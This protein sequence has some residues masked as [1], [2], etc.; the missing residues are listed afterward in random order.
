MIIHKYLIQMLTSNE[1]VQ[2]INIKRFNK[3]QTSPYMFVFDLLDHFLFTKT[4]SF[5][6]FVNESQTF[7]NIT[8]TLGYYI[9]KKRLI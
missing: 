7:I 6:Y 2:M 1:I 5:Q 4:F 3:C 8:I 9:M